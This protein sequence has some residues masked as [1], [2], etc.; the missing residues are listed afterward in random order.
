M[1]SGMIVSHKIKP[2]R[3]S[4]QDR[5]EP[6]LLRRQPFRGLL[7]VT[8]LIET[9][10]IQLPLRSILYALLPGWTKPDARWSFK[11]SLLVGM[12]KH[13]AYH[14]VRI[15]VL[16][17][18]VNKGTLP[19]VPAKYGVT[20]VWVQPVH[21][22][23]GLTGEMKHLFDAGGC[24][25]KRTPA[26]WY[27]ENH[28]GQHG[29]DAKLGEKVVLFFHGGGYRELNASPT[30]PTTNNLRI[31]LD[32]AVK[33]GKASAPKRA[34]AVEYR[35]TTDGATFPDIFA[36][37]LASWIYLV[38]ELRF[39]PKNIVIVGDSAGGNL[40][41][42]LLRYLRDER[43][44]WKELGLPMDSPIADGVI[45]SSPWIDVSGSFMSAG[46]SSSGSRFSHLD[47]LAESA[48]SLGRR[49]LVKG[50][51]VTALHSKWISP[52][53]TDRSIDERL[54]DGFPRGLCFFG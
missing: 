3:L 52:V 27:G 12:L 50:L 42:A 48:L 38:R 24:T 28:I 32:A 26:Y 6:G 31:V 30:C 19:R 54:F 44:M 16:A 47:Y 53:T 39:E 15:G 33:S 5:R 8:L 18:S 2:V 35:L 51:P 49:D 40:A 13:F 43:P 7:F 10:L 9:L 11:R 41:L 45:L 23:T 17:V 22:Q 14:R 29:R 36:D 46:P 37:A 20:A 1:S 4:D 21:R 25:T 34:L